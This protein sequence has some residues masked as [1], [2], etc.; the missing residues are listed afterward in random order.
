MRPAPTHEQL[1]QALQASRITLPLDMAMRSPSLAI[2]LTNTALALAQRPT[3][4]RSIDHKRL[5]AGDTD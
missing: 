1:L 4:R 3:L 2:A 5:A